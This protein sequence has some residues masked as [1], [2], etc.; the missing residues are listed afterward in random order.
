MAETVAGAAATLP[1]QGPAGAARSRRAAGVVPWGV[2]AGALAWG[3]AGNWRADHLLNYPW[4]VWTPIGYGAAKGVFFGAL[5]G[6]VAAL[7]LRLIGAAERR[8]FAPTALAA[9]VA[10]LLPGSIRDFLGTPQPRTLYYYDWPRPEA[11]WYW[12]PL[13]HEWLT[14]TVLPA[15]GCALLLATGVRLSARLSPPKR[16]NC[17]LL[18]LTGTVLFFLPAVASAGLPAPEGNGQHVNESFKA[19]LVVAVVS[20][21]VLTAALISG[22][23]LRHAT[24]ATRSED[25]APQAD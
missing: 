10:G 9:L 3:L 8:P 19:G 4:N 5:A 13:L 20:L 18:A 12:A 17:V 23:R 11:E 14:Y 1:E 7:T 24:R 25:A 6:W 2:A 16:L 15:L 22:L 21:G